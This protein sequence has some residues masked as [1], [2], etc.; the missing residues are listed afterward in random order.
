MCDRFCYWRREADSG[1]VSSSGGTRS[2]NQGSFV[3]EELTDLLEE[4]VLKE[5][6]A[7]S[8]RGGVPGVDAGR[9]LAAPEVSKSTIAP[10]RFASNVT[11][12]T[13]PTRNH[14]RSG[15]GIDDWKSKP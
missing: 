8:E 2:P 5:F 13:A 7:I 4:A 3:I 14:A 11:Q 9:Q 12:G 10:C 1:L 15:V 6:E